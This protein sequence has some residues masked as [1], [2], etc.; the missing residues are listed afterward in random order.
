M[1]LSKAQSA[2]LKRIQRCP[3]GYALTRKEDVTAAILFQAGLI[4]LIG[5]TAYPKAA[6]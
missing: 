6:T 1:T 3:K 4:R 5:I 2:L